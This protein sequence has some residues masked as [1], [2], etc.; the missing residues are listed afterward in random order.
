[1]Y[2]CFNGF[3]N[4]HFAQRFGKR[5]KAATLTT[6]LTRLLHFACCKKCSGSSSLFSARRICTAFSLSNPTFGYVAWPSQYLTDFGH[7]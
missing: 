3:Q 5:A 6:L 1:L 7:G 2:D 4:D